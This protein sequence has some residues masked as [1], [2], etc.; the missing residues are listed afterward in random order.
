MAIP[1]VLVYLPISEGLAGT[2]L[3]HQFHLCDSGRG[4]DNDAAC[5]GAL[6]LTLPDHTAS[7]RRL[8]T[9]A[10]HPLCSKAGIN[11]LGKN[12]VRLGKIS[13]LQSQFERPHKFEVV[14]VVVQNYHFGLVAR[15]RDARNL[16]S[17][18]E[19]HRIGAMTVY[20]G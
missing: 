16:L 14:S 11:L 10:L 15:H 13:I 8:D 1:Q 3:F 6:N 19:C 2:A 9:D 5:L 18:K 17:H 12:P 4:R 7:F 20:Q